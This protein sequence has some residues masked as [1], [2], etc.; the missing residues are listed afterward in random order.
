M[1]RVEN[2]QLLNNNGGAI[3]SYYAGQLFLEGSAFQGNTGKNPGILLWY[4][5]PAGQA[6]ITGTLF[7]QNHAD[8]IYLGSPN[9]DAAALHHS[10]E[11]TVWITNTQ[12]ISNTAN[13]FTGVIMIGP[14]TDGVTITNSDFISNTGQ[15][16]NGG[17]IN[18]NGGSGTGPLVITGG[19]F[20]N[21][22]SGFY[23]GA[24]EATNGGS[25]TISGATFDSNTAVVA[26][27]AIR[28]HG[29]QTTVQ[30]STFISNTAGS[31]TGGA[32]TGES[33]NLSIA[34]SRL[35]NNMA[36]S[37]GGAI[38]LY[39]GSLTLQRAALLNNR[40]TGSSGQGGGI[41]LSSVSYQIQESVIANNQA[42]Y[43]GGGFVSSISGNSSIRNT[44]FSGNSAGES[45][46]NLLHWGG[47]GTLTINNATFTG[48]NSPLSGS[49]LAGVGGTVNIVN[50][51]IAN[52]VGGVNCY[53]PLTSL[54]HNL[55]S[56]NTC[57]FNQSNDL[58]NTNPLLGPLQDNGGNTLTHLLLT[59][60][61]ALDTGSD[62]ACPA[63][64]QRGVARPADGD[65]DGT[66]QCDI[67]AVENLVL[68]QLSVANGSV[69]EGNGGAVSMVFA[70]TLSAQSSQPV[71]VTYTTQNGTAQ[72]GSD[73]TAV[74]DV[75][76]IP[77]GVTTGAITISV[78]G[79]TLVESDETFNVV[80]NNPVNVVL[81]NTSAQGVIL[82][83]D[84]SG[85][86]S[87]QLFLPLII[88]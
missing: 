44:T 20:R 6:V 81:A 74:S 79:D 41:Y 83:D 38:Y 68:P 23:G 56:A 66:I 52:P 87:S 70:A 77:A 78:N 64:D 19:T 48:G 85:A 10:N 45:G 53:S 4:N 36:G 67:G 18:Y 82:N 65:Q 55:E 29:A 17:A 40:A 63:T 24:I 84:P 88:K 49:N 2:T 62:T 60:S 43:L 27:G 31:D 76:V 59:G 34:D 16:G 7:L 57:G 33:V 61:P 54:G 26:G 32:I 8:H 50:T 46:G 72:A 1:L 21:N 28:V 73:Y 11:G 3:Y 15:T 37:S 69:L 86:S 42:N 5:D 35:E 30:N 13:R 12:F 14:S 25:L 51:I 71:M 22:H 58:T 39:Q 80:L 75:L 47:S 9:G